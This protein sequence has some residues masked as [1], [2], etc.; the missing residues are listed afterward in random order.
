MKSKFLNFIFAILTVALTFAFVLTIVLSVSYTKAEAE[1]YTV[2]E[3][4]GYYAE[5]TYYLTEKAYKK[6]L[7]DE[8]ETSGQSHKSPVTVSAAGVSLSTSENNW[9]IEIDVPGITY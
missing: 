5:T 9:K 1:T 7:K 8:A 6:H 4:D 3:D 2:Y